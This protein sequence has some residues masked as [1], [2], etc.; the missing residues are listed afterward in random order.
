MHLTKPPDRISQKVWEDV[1]WDK[2]SSSG[3]LDQ[4]GEGNWKIYRENTVTTRIETVSKSKRSILKES[5]DFVEER[6]LYQSFSFFASLPSLIHRTYCLIY[7]SLVFK[8]TLYKFIV[9]GSLGLNPFT[10]WAL[11]SKHRTYK[12]H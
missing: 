11:D 6:F 3:L 1:S 4:Q 5:S 10:F 12:Y 7:W 8:L 9:L 2:H